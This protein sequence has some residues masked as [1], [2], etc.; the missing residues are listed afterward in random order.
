MGRD[1]KG[2]D[3]EWSNPLSV[4]MPRN[5]VFSVDL[6]EKFM[7]KILLLNQLL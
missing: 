5:R 7:K 4:S 3:S 1:K 6:L 2:G